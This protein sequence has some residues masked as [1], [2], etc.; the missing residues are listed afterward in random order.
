M[1]YDL[2]FKALVRNS[3]VFEALGLEAS[4]N[5]HNI[6]FGTC[7]KWRKQAA[8]EG[9]DWDKARAAAHM[10]GEGIE[11]LSQMMLSTFVTLYHTI[12]EQINEDKNMKGDV[13]AEA[14]SRM[15]DAYHK[16][17]AATT[18]GAP[19]LAR[20]SIALELVEMLMGFVVAEFP[21]HGAAIIEILEKFEPTVRTKYA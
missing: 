5:K 18:R 4:A 12:V 17:V 15:S 8:L 9:D 19:K 11:T 10:A 13:K 1:A 3:Y 16:T 2:K 14:L 7:A 20:L 21:Q 6:P